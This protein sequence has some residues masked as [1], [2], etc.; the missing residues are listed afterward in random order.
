MAST[1]T[2]AIA[3]AIATQEGFY[4]SGSIA[5]R[6][7][8]PGNLRSWGAR[9]IRNGY[10]YFDT[11]EDGW[12]ALY[13]QI[14]KNIGRGLTLEEFFGGKPGVYSGYS[15]AADKNDPVRY[16]QNVSGW[17]G[18]PLGV[19]LNTVGTWDPSKAATLLQTR[20][21]RLPLPR[22]SA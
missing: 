21:A 18:V 1:L 11:D 10:A 3:A 8:N 15:P 17:T 6:N 13:Q 16:A 9:P 22:V 14:D 4:I 19:K 5:Q 12:N 7:H 20:V 2:Q